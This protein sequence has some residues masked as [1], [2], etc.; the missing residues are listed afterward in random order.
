MSAVVTIVLSPVYLQFSSKREVY[1]LDEGII[2]ISPVFGFFK[3]NKFARKWKDME[4]L[5]FKRL[6]ENIIRLSFGIVVRNAE[7]GEYISTEYAA[8]LPVE[9]MAAFAV[10]PGGLNTR[11]FIIKGDKTIID[12]IENHLP[13]NAIKSNV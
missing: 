11:V 8:Q 1:I 12:F 7:T 9:L 5:R 6:K 10:S 3:P 4:F 2:I 13:K